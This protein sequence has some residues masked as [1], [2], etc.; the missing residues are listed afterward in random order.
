MNAKNTRTENV[1]RTRWP[2]GEDSFAAEAEQSHSHA[3]VMT[4]LGTCPQLC[5]WPPHTVSGTQHLTM[6]GSF[7]ESSCET[8]TLKARHLQGHFGSLRA[9]MHIPCNQEALFKISHSISVNF[10]IF[11]CVFFK[12]LF[13]YLRERER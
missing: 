8:E 4:G 5:A 7:Q 6:C 3:G 11:V 2:L 1:H 13:I 12:I 10:H 9:N